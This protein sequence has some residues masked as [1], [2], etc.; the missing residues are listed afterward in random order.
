MIA[1]KASSFYKDSGN[2]QYDIR[3]N[4]KVDINGILVIFGYFKVKWDFFDNNSGY[5]P[6]FLAEFWTLMYRVL[7]DGS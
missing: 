2:I 7:S 6:K 3:C 4:H 5:K 1:Q